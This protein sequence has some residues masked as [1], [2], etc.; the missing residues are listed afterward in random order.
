MNKSV[1]ALFSLGLLLSLFWACEP[2]PIF[3]EEPQISWNRFSVDTL[4][5]FTGQ[6]KLIVNFTDGDGDIGKSGNDTTYNMI[7][8]DN[9]TQDS[10]YYVMP[11]VPQQGV[12]NGISGEVEVDISTVCC[13]VPGFPVLYSNI[14]NVYDSL[15]YTIMI[16]DRAGNWSNEI[17]SD[18]LYIRCFE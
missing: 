3:P 15:S 16:R 6:M 2:A 10:I 12:A 9:R 17:E 11:Y 4:Q 7:I 1:F 8:I 5:Q 18:P 13:M 14:P